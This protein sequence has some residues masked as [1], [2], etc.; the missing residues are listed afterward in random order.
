MPLPIVPIGS[1]ESEPNVLV[2]NDPSSALQRALFGD[3]GSAQQILRLQPVSKVEARDADMLHRIWL[4]NDRRVASDNDSI[5]TYRIPDDIGDYD[6][7]RLK[8]AGY[9]V[10][11]GRNVE[12]SEEGDKIVRK[13]I[14]E[15]A[16]EFDV[17]RTRQKYDPETVLRSK[18]NDERC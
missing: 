17:E 13:K 15:A 10:G 8:T 7:I 3:G 6:V 16:S 2:M 14:L 9:V 1:R 12:L 18:G 5:H 4:S 11:K